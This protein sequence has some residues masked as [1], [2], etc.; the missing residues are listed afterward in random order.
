MKALKKRRYIEGPIT[1]GAFHLSVTFEG[2]CWL[3]RGAPPLELVDRAAKLG[4]HPEALKAARIDMVMEA[5]TRS[6]QDAARTSRSL[7][8]SWRMW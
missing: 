7:L 3:L 2:A 1:A 8:R 6:E 5:H 4:E